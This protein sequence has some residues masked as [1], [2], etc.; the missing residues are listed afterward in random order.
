MNNVRQDGAQYVLTANHCIFS[1]PSF[2]V[3]GFNYQQPVCYKSRQEA[4]LVPPKPQTVHGVTLVSKWE[5][6]DYA[7]L[8][9]AER[10]PVEYNAYFAGWDATMRAPADVYGIHHPYG[11]VKKISSFFGQ[12]ILS[13]WTPWDRIKMHWKIPRWNEGATERGSSGSALF[14]TLG[15]VVSHLRGGS[16]SC[17]SPDGWDMYGGL[18]ADFHYPP[19]N[20]RLSKYLDP[21]NTGSRIMNGISV[22]DLYSRGATNVGNNNHNNHNGNN[23]NNGNMNRPTHPHQQFHPHQNH[24]MVRP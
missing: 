11:D 1:D 9:I 6:S 15:Q 7:L 10:I 3:I 5:T 23:G 19:E 24:R 12:T 18:F 20:V 17:T 13:T 21:D 22:K 2:F 4:S 16:A 14:N 8:K